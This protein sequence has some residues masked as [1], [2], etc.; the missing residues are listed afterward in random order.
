MGTAFD[1]SGENDEL[2]GIVPRAVEH[3]FIGIQQQQQ[4]AQEK[5]AI[6]PE[7]KVNAQFMEVMI[8]NYFNFE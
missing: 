5:G 1:V 2:V 6:P 3:L 8:E 4:A 7:F